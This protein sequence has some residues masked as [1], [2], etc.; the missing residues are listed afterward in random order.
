MAYKTA[1]IILPF[2]LILSIAGVVLVSFY[3]SPVANN[4]VLCGD[5]SINKKLANISEIRWYIAETV[6]CNSV[7]GACTRTRN[8]ADR[9]INNVYQMYVQTLGLKLQRLLVPCSNKNQIF[10]LSQYHRTKL[11]LRTLKGFKEYFFKPQFLE[12]TP[13][14]YF[15]PLIYK[16]TRT[17]LDEGATGPAFLSGPR[18]FKGHV[19]LESENQNSF[20]LYIEILVV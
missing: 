7:T 15:K 18:R 3:S 9:A 13:K 1:D 20:S 6:T 5:T 16:D 8:G 12:R 17:L 4:D 11:S 19:F 2:T 14:R 10:P